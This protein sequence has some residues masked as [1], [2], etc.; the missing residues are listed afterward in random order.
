MMVL[1]FVAAVA[2]GCGID[3]ADIAAETPPL[4]LGYGTSPVDST[5]YLFDPDGL[6]L[7]VAF[8][9]PMD[10]QEI[11]HLQLVPTPSDMGPVRNP[12]S[13]PRQIVFES[14]VLDTTYQAYRMV[15]D[16]PTMDQPEILSYYSRNK[17]AFEGAIQGSVSIAR[18]DERARGALVYALVPP[19]LEGDFPLHGEEDTFLG[20]PVLGVTKA[21]SIQSLEGAWFRLAGLELFKR[22]IVVAILDTNDDG[23]YDPSVDW[24]GYYADGIGNPLDVASGVGFGS[25]L[26]PPLPELRTDIDF[27][28][29]PPGSLD[30]GFE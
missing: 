4:R 26:E 3:K 10:G 6:D 23:I 30:P 21:L 8:L 18:G 7:V 22:Y 27:W 5:E 29:Q 24:W 28:I 20:R 11:T 2:S 25:A 17:S 14:V 12:A 15:I 9:R 1:L 19:G 13:N 16:G